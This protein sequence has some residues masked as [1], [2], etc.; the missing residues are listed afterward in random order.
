MEICLPALTSLY[1]AILPEQ[2]KAALRRVEMELDEADELVCNQSFLSQTGT[3]LMTGRFRKWKSRFRGYPSPSDPNTR[4]AS[5][6]ARQILH[7]TRSSP[8][9]CMRKLHARICSLRAVVVHLPRPMS[10]MA[11]ATARVSW[12][13]PLFSRTALGACRRASASRSRQRSKAP[14]FFGASS[15]SASR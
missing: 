1:I 15:D 7:A 2:K 12:P 4:P 5:G 9:R 13:G 6:L 10:P 14:A 3:H 11:R 8:A